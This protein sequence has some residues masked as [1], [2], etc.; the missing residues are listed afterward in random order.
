MQ[1]D[2][3]WRARWER[4]SGSASGT[5]DAPPL[6]AADERSL[7]EIRDRLDEDYGPPLLRRDSP[8]P[9]R[10][11]PG[12]RGEISWLAS[13]RAAGALGPAPR[14][15][16]MAG[17]ALIAACAV[18]T[19]VLTL[20]S[21]PATPPETAGLKPAQPAPP[22][23]RPD[24]TP[25]PV[26][27][28][29]APVPAPPQSAPAVSEPASTAPRPAP[30]PEPPRVS[31]PEPAAPE[32]A[33]APPPGQAPPAPATLPPRAPALKQSDGGGA[34]PSR[35]GPARSVPAP[36]RVPAKPKSPSPVDEPVPAPRRFSAQPA[37]MGAPVPAPPAARTPTRPN[38]PVSP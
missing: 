23:G 29:T 36:K 14:R 22:Q 31:T 37:R 2:E 15:M 33:R 4:A 27:P 17:A 21:K 13:R 16:W 34:D 38:R 10:R 30:A 35:A 9:T 18:A 32:P 7:E 25:L 1:M 28:P 3:S 20:L 11:Q 6:S 19:F 5:E 24:L 26:P 12:T 8:K